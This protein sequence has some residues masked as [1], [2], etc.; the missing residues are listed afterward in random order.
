LKDTETTE[1]FTTGYDTQ[2]VNLLYYDD[3]FDK[4]KHFVYANHCNGL[5]GYTVDGVQT[6]EDIYSNLAD[7]SKITNLSDATNPCKYVS[8]IDIEV[9][10]NGTLVLENCTLMF[11]QTAAS[12]LEFSIYGN[13]IANYSN[14]TSFSN[15]YY[16]FYTLENSSLNLK[17]SYVSRVGVANATFY[18]GLELTTSNFSLVNTMISNNFRG[19]TLHA[20]GSELSNAIVKDPM[21][22]TMVLMLELL[23]IIVK[24]FL[25][26]FLMLKLETGYFNR[27][28]KIFDGFGF[29][30]YF[31]W[32][33][34]WCSIE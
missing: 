19:L 15:Y 25:V 21:T 34:F 20:D 17:N 7:D 11:N 32:I 29:E 16:R 28:R 6:I 2:A 22:W 10:S 26:I 33:W 31:G 5:S 13:L 3:Y 18:S 12:P 4:S 24:L 8:M 14:I 9:G 30:L 23:E 1:L 27:C